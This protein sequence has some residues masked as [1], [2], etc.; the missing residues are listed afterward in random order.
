MKHRSSLYLA[1]LL[2]LLFSCLTLVAQD[3]F[4]A[5]LEPGRV[6]LPIVFEPNRGQ[7]EDGTSFLSRTSAYAVFVHPEKVVLAIPMSSDNEGVGRQPSLVALE[8]LSSNE[9]AELEGLDPQ[10]GKSNYFIGQQRTKW[11]SGIPHYGKVRLKSVYP[12]I[13][14]VYY[15]NDGELEYDFILSPLAD[16][17]KLNFRVTGAETELDSDGNLLVKTGSGTIQLKK[18][19]I[20]Q[21]IEGSRHPV[22]GSFRMR[23]NGQIGMQVGRYD[24]T[25]RLIIDPVLSY[26]TLIG[27]N[28]NT[29]IQG[30]AVDPSGNLYVTGT[31][32][33]TNY[34]TVNAYQSTNHGSSDVFVTKL[35]PAGNKVL[36][37][38]Y[39]GG[40]A[41]I[42]LPESRWMG[43]VTRTSLER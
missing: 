16:P 17:G 4:E 8:L 5:S 14:L 19:A 28:N 41:L 43:A 39:L 3:A 1:I 31:T 37:S 26:S 7:T 22:A 40:V 13:D 9:N 30:I 34:P 10:P 35:N 20:Y 27:A 23:R 25:Q 42:M 6:Q 29:Q 32:F 21:V 11:I 36:Y 33:A 12:G 38:T 18:P 24:R 15:G 2:S